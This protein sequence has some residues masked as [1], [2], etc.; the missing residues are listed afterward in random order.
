MDKILR[1]EIVREVQKAMEGINERY[2][3]GDVLCEHIGSLTKRF[4]KEH[5]HMLERTRIEWTDAKGV[6]HRQPWLY[7]LNKMK[8]QLASGKLKELQETDGS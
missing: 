7:P 8:L 1:A 5:G 2:V 6:K 4:L 3:T